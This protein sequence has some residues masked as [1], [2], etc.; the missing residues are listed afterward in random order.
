MQRCRKPRNMGLRLYMSNNFLLWRERNFQLR[1]DAYTA[2]IIAENNS[3]GLVRSSLNPYIKTPVC[4]SVHKHHQRG[5]RTFSCRPPSY[6]TA[7]ASKS[8]M[9]ATFPAET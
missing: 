6:A 4:Q 9:P 8:A 2:K 5:Y 3:R 7:P 1:V